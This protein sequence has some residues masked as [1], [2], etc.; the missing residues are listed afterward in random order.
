MIQAVVDDLAFVEAEAVLRPAGASLEPVSGAAVRL[1][2]QAGDAFAAQ[3]RVSTPLEAGAAVVTGAGDLAADYVL[4]VIIQDPETLT[5]R[6]TVRRAL[7]SAWERCAE[8]GIR[9]VAAGPVGA[10]AGLLDVEGAVE[11]MAETFPAGSGCPEHL[12]I[13]LDRA[14]DRD[15]ADAVLRR[16][17][18]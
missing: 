1:D 2:R 8:W 11:L 16:G 3:R 7:L 6:E 9:T 14:E 18:G 13:V 5:T 15:L 4:H 17:A 10:G 12:M